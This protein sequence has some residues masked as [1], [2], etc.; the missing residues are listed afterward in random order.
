METLR[1]GGATQ[2]LSAVIE[3]LFL[4]SQ[5]L[6]LHLHLLVTEPSDETF[7]IFDSVVGYAGIQDAD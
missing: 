4:H 5:A 6:T 1:I 7:T 2:T 3:K